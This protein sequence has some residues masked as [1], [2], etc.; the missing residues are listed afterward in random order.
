MVVSSIKRSWKVG[1]LGSMAFFS[2]SRATQRQ[3]LGRLDLAMHSSHA[4]AGGKHS[5]VCSA[6]LENECNSAE[7]RFAQPDSG[8]VGLSSTGQRQIPMCLAR[9][10]APAPKCAGSWHPLWW[11]VRS[12]QHLLTHP[13]RL[14][15]SVDANSTHYWAQ[16]PA[17]LPPL[18]GYDPN[19]V[20]VWL[21]PAVALLAK[22][23]DSWLARSDQAHLRSSESLLVGSSYQFS[24]F[25]NFFRLLA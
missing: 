9:C 6:A 17:W 4:W 8:A 18:R 12:W 24:S 11:G 13:D 3:P 5:H 7:S 1:S 23:S 15:A 22:A 21:S 19:A 2:T 14:Y 10:P 20:T 16:P 25:A